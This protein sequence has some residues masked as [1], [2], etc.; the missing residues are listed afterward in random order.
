MAS[1]ARGNSGD[2]ALV[3]GAHA[4]GVGVRKMGKPFEDSS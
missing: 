4:G 3:G 1:D 2:A